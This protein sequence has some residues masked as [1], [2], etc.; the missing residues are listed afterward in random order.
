MSSDFWGGSHPGL[1][2]MMSFGVSLGAFFL[3]AAVLFVPQVREALRKWLLE[4]E[5]LL[6]AAE[7]GRA[8]QAP[9]RP[10]EDAQDA[11][12]DDRTEAGKPESAAGPS[13]VVV[14][15][16]PNDRRPSATE[17]TGT[18][19]ER[20]EPDRPSSKN[21]KGSPHRGQKAA[22]AKAD[23]E[24]TMSHPNA[25]L[26]LQAE[27]ERPATSQTQPSVL[28]GDSETHSDASGEQL[29]RVGSEESA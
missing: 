15:Q 2:L 20:A 7:E 14:F 5:Y 17:A 18:S 1:M 19:V 11:K 9:D 26:D 24:A 16:D 13:D 25:P 23:L 12:V 21:S 3:C 4:E 8:E 29:S 22:E 10:L 6:E 27:A 28:S